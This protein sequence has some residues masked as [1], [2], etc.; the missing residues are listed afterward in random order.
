MD[1]DDP[2]R[3]AELAELAYREGRYDDAIDCLCL[4][5]RS[6]DTEVQPPSM[7]ATSL[8]NL[9]LLQFKQGKLHTSA[10]SLAAALSMVKDTPSSDLPSRI[11]YAAAL[12]HLKLGNIEVSAQMLKV[13]YILYVDIY[14]DNQ[15]FW[16]RLIECC[17]LQHSIYGGG[18]GAP[19][20][21]H[22]GTQQSSKVVLPNYIYS[23][24]D[25]TSKP[26]NI[27]DAFNGDGAPD[28]SLRAAEL[29]VLRAK[30]STPVSSD[31]LGNISIQEMY[32]RL[33]LGEIDCALEVGVKCLENFASPA[34][35]LYTSI[36][37]WK[38][39]NLQESKKHLH[40]GASMC[41]DVGS[42]EEVATMMNLAII[43]CIIEEEQTL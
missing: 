16:M 23:P 20:C 41:T 43:D 37:Y 17:I 40:L 14:E 29:Y 19:H 12:V 5:S 33:A 15:L 25:E 10:C 42:T 24:I 2:Y 18:S 34:V 27:A 39:G 22:G 31:V 4:G 9:A 35:H 8:Y 11:L 6:V 28:L 38:L 13:A 36:A 32:L 30:C 3:E 7:Y 1:S 21:V 26:S